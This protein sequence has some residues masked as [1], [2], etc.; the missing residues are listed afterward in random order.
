[1][2]DVMRGKTRRDALRCVA[3]GVAL[4]A[5]EWVRLDVSGWV[6]LEGLGDGKSKQ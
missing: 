5:L 6:R 3:I 4:R 1:M 2:C